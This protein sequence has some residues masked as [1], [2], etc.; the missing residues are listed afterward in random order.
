MRGFGTGGVVGVV[1]VVTFGA[2][3]LWCMLEPWL[4]GV[5]GEGVKGPGDSASS[6]TL[7]PTS[8]QA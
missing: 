1:G 5:P 4:L 6:A 7:R 8:L 2:E 3:L